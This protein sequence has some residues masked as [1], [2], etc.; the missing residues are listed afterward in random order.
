MSLTSLRSLV[1]LA[2]LLL[3]TSG[4]VAASGDDDEARIRELLD[5]FMGGASAGC[6]TMHDRFW[7]PELIY[8]SSDGTRFGKAELMQGVEE[9]LEDPQ[10]RGP[11][12]RAE[13]VH[14]RFLDETAV[15]TFRLL[16]EMPATEDQPE[17][18]QQY[19]NTGVFVQNEGQWQAITW[20][21]TRRA[22]ETP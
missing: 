18:V 4:V 19:F 8:T 11:R 14:V 12:Y 15:V 3:F 10:S 20:Q 21:A 9:A 2:I 16:A 22:T 13:D 5:D 17:G 7:H 1:S 6:P